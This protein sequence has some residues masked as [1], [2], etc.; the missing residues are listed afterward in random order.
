MILAREL[1]IGNRV[2]LKHS[3]SAHL[4]EIVIDASLLK[5]IASEK[6][7]I[8]IF[9]LPIDEKILSD[10]CGMTA[11]AKILPDKSV[12]CISRMFYPSGGYVL[13]YYGWRI[14]LKGFHHLQNILYFLFEEELDVK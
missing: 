6:S 9:P 12:L 4:S 10:R 8:S 7:G 3:D 5:D 1:R 2:L 13:Q 11:G 14:E